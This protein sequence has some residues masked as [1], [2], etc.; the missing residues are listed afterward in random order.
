MKR[1]LGIALSCIF[2]LTGC[3]ENIGQINKTCGSEQNISSNYN[4]EEEETDSQY[5]SNDANNDGNEG[6][7]ISIEPDIE[8]SG[9]S[10]PNLLDYVEDSVYLELVSSLNSDEFFVENVEAIYYPKE[11][12]DE[13]EFNSKENI[14]FGY[15]AS[16][17]DAAFGGE[18]YVFT[19]SE[20]GETVPVLLESFEPEDYGKII[21]DVIVGSGVILICVTVSTVSA[22]VGAPAVGMIFACSAST[23]TSFAKS[24]A[25]IGGVA[26]TIT[27]AYQTEDIELALKAGLKESASGFKWGA[28]SGALIGGGKEALALK[29]ATINGLTMNEVAKIQSESMFPLDV[30]KEFHSYEEYEVYKNAGLYPKIVNGKIALVQDIDLN[31][32][33]PGQTK[34]N[35]ELMK[36]GKTPYCAKTGEPYELHHVNQNKNGTLAILK[37]KSEHQTSFGVLHEK[38]GAGEGVHNP[39]SPNYDPSWDKSREEFWKAYAAL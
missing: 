10:D 1:L 23:A 28:I 24:G 20:N 7:S 2:I 36:D 21:E 22:G 13:L 32:I 16:Q 39:E 9:L 31:Y 4:G 5:L 14:Y 35:L 37:K 26:A 27:T 18:K 38:M 6:I 29:G 33:A 15:T 19:L 34:T 30:I 3:G 12:I 11:Y 17:L 8:F 25:V